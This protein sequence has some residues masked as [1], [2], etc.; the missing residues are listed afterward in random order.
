MSSNTMSNAATVPT[1]NTQSRTTKRKPPPPPPKNKPVNTGFKISNMMDKLDELYD[2]C[3]WDFIK[4]DEC[5]DAIA[6][7]HLTAHPVIVGYF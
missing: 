4:R 2:R 1:S 5:A 3:E 6:V 7:S